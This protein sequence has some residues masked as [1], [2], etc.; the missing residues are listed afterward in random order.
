M[1]KT[2]INGKFVQNYFL[3]GLEIENASR[4]KIYIKLVNKNIIFVYGVSLIKSY[5]SRYFYLLTDYPPL[6]S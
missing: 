5:S 1:N 4:L 3:H 2:I 6:F